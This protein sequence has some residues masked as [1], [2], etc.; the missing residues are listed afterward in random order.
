M[1]ASWVYFVCRSFSHRR[2]ATSSR[3][4]ILSLSFIKCVVLDCL[5]LSC[6]CG[7]FEVLNLETLAV[8]AAAVIVL[9]KF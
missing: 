4:L 7:W 6:C 5:L 8:S 3:V 2:L 1:L 9:T